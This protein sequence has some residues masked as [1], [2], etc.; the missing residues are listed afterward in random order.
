MTAA[1]DSKKP[2]WLPGEKD[3]KENVAKWLKEWFPDKEYHKTFLKQDIDGEELR[4]LTD[5]E[6]EKLGVS[7]GDMKKIRRF[8]APAGGAAGA[9]AAPAAVELTSDDFD[10][11]KCTCP[12]PDDSE[13]KV[14]IRIDECIKEC[15]GVVSE[16]CP[17]VTSAFGR[18]PPLMLSRC[19]RGG[20]T[21]ALCKLFD[22]LEGG[23]NPVFISFNGD[24]LRFTCSDKEGETLLDRL[25]RAIAWSLAMHSDRC[26]ELESA[27]DVRCDKDTLI[28]YLQEKKVVLLIDELN[29]LL[30]RGADMAQAHAVGKFLRSEF[31]DKA[32]KYLVFTTHFPID[33]LLTTVIGRGESSKRTVR[34]VNLPQAAEKWEDMKLMAGCDRLTK[35]K[36]AYYAFIPSLIFECLDRGFDISL[37]FCDFWREVDC[38]PR[39]A[40]LRKHFL[41]E[42]FDGVRIVDSPLRDFD[43][44]T[45]Y[46]KD[47]H[48]QWVLG[49]AGKLCAKLGWTDVSELIKKLDVYSDDSKTGRAWE[50]IVSICIALRCYQAML[51]KVTPHQMLG[52]PEGLELKDFSVRWIPDNYDNTKDALKWWKG[53]KKE[54][55]PRASLLVPVVSDFNVVDCLLVCET[56]SECVVTGFQQKEGRGLPTESPP[57]GVR[58]VVL[59]GRA[60]EKAA[61]PKSDRL[62]P[63][64]YV[65][66][67]DVRDFLGVSLGMLCP[68]F[69]A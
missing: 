43:A 50:F 47:A 19:A 15:V 64:E 18:V 34:V 31:L 22:R 42:F 38:E 55:F 10:I 4:T 9:A 39:M 57:S 8:V 24:A 1:P 27:E 46:S 67:E 62:K 66:A 68:A 61:S 52:F 30:N 2:K 63:W 21:T 36:A 16:H 17:E 33:T 60:P 56:G 20:K 41:S 3:S 48:V 26:K 37:R 7:L 65:G 11:E 59:R 32:D 44:L 12:K 25:I 14:L 49:Y 28:G 40:T 58:G 6:F 51:C 29:V 45:V 35:S 54:I 5:G 13:K 23:R 69:E 53:V